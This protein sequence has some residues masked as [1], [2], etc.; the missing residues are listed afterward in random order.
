MIELVFSPSFLLLDTY[1]KAISPSFGLIQFKDIFQIFLRPFFFFKKQNKMITV[2][3][4]P[5][6]YTN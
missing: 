4:N 5:I 6:F 1:F 2:F 3:L